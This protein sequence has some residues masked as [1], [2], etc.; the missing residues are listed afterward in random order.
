L[1]EVEKRLVP[2]RTSNFWVVSLV[3]V[4]M[5]T[6]LPSGVLKATLGSGSRVLE[7]MRTEPGRTNFEV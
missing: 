4:T 6:L 5:R 2:L 7:A 3:L 1:R